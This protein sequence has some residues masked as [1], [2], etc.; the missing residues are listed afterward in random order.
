MKVEQIL[1]VKAI[2][3]FTNMYVWHSGPL[4]GRDRPKACKKAV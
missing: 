3:D 4:D 1:G 2:K